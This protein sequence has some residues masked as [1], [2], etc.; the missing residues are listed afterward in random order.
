MYMCV[1]VRIYAFNSHSS[2]THF[3]LEVL[4]VGPKIL[5]SFSG[6]M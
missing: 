5:F 4:A 6:A 1:C 3:P 2:D